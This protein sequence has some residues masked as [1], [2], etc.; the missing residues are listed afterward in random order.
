MTITDAQRDAARDQPPSGP[1]QGVLIADFGRVLAGP[2]CTMLLAD[3]GA[4]VV[5]VESASGDE[6]RG[7]TPPHRDGEST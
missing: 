7:W 5:K 6:T 1:F 3:L 4:T 2:Y